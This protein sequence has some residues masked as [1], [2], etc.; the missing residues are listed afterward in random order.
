MRIKA[1][2]FVL[3]FLLIQFI[4]SA[5]IPL[6]RLQAW[7]IGDSVV[8]SGTL[9]SQWIDI[10][11]NEYHLLQPT[12]NRKP[13]QNLNS[14]SGHA[15]IE[16]DGVNDYL[17]VT[18]G[19][20]FSQPIT[21]FIVWR[22][23]T[24]VA[25]EI[26][27]GLSDANA[28]VFNYPY[29]GNT[30]LRM[31]AGAA[32]GISITYSKPV[33]PNFTISSLFFTNPD[34]LYDNGVLMGQY[35][36]GNN[37]LTGFNVGTRNYLDARFMD[38]DIAE[39]IFYDTLLNESERVQVET[40]LMDKYAPPVNLGADQIIDYSLC[41]IEL[42]VSPDYSNI[43][44]STGS[45]DDTITVNESG[46]YWVQVTDIF[47]RISSDTIY[48]QYPHFAFPDTTFCFGDSAKYVSTLT[49]SYTY[50]WSD[51]STDSA[52]TITG[53]GTYWLNLTDSLGC[54]LSDTFQ[55]VVDSFALEASLGPD[56]T[57][58]SGES[59]GLT[60]GA[61]EATTYLWSTSDTTETIVLPTPGDYSVTATNSF[62][63]VA[64]DT[65][66]VIFQGYKPTIG[67]IADSVCFGFP[68]SFT[69]TSA[70][71]APDEL[72]S[73]TWIIDGNTF[74][75][76]NPIYTFPS[77][78]NQTVSLSVVTDSG[79]VAS[80]SSTVFVIPPPQLSFQPF[81]GCSGQKIQ[82]NNQSTAGYGS[83][84]S[85]E[86]MAIDSNNIMVDY[87]TQTHPL[88]TFPNSGAHT[89]TLI[90]ISSAGCSDTLTEDIEIRNTPP[91]DFSWQ[92]TCFG[93]KTAFTEQTQVPAHEI[94][95]ERQWWFGDGTSTNIPSPL[96]LYNLT[97]V[98]DVSLR[99]KSLNGCIDTITKQV[100]IYELPEAGFYFSNPCQYSPVQFFDTSSV[101]DDTIIS[102]LWTFPD[103]D[104]TSVPSPIRFFNDTLG[105][106]V[107]LL[108][109]TSN[110]CIDTIWKTVNVHPIP[111]AAFTLYPEYGIPPL[112][113]DF[114]NLSNGAQNYQWFFGDGDFSSL[115]NP[116]HT[117]NTTSIFDVSLIAFNEYLCSDTAT[118]IVYVI[119][120]SYDITITDI[121]QQSDQNLMTCT[122]ELQNLGTRIIRTLQMQIQI[123]N[124]FPITELWEGK[125]NPGEKASF[126][127][128]SLLDESLLASRKSICFSA[129][130]NEDVIDVQPLNNIQCIILENGYYI[131]ST[132]PNPADN[133]LFVTFVLK[134]TGIYHLQLIASDGKTVLNEEG[135]DGTKGMNSV[136]ID[137]SSINQGVYTLKIFDDNHVAL[138]K[139]VIAR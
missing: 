121:T 60:S 74:T 105:Y 128:S 107:N 75:N 55:V 109:T 61:P 117:F 64:T 50:E 130:P 29:N 86:W 70:A 66:T 129:Q 65:I 115:P 7:Y 57:V 91:V 95:I 63:C 5:Q 12:E 72:F 45:T 39:F 47:G 21:I 71:T 42:G 94:I 13:I 40:Y 68:T 83:I 100:T 80:L 43:L 30:T 23:N 93:Q 54:S 84:L 20:T 88:L 89:L 122:V 22:I 97:G 104:T 32:F 131:M 10:S 82:I 137:L 113:V 111:D 85:W 24:L 38:G 16:F 11:G 126:T 136:R 17:Q 52:L 108:V 48:I 35:D 92:Q 98:Y 138:Q 41:P 101:V 67:F 78:G 26:F 59:I 116:T 96:H 77:Q 135:L 124:S 8:Q 44:W 37:S 31:Y 19:T 25:Q 99:N 2:Y 4:G 46:S 119:P 1:T 34:R 134:E 118:G 120:S 33:S 36:V 73:W 125:L 62:G 90:A 28:L 133:E 110:G 3:V 18:F 49:G 53:A 106:P 76:Q 27:D 81:M 58:C 51:L 14:I 132:K 9:V 56:I 139:I 103:L 112:E 6:N 69:D 123:D 114:T 79:C 127:Y 87:S 102:L 15:S